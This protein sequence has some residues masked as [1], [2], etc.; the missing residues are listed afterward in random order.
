[1][2]RNVVGRNDGIQVIFDCQFEKLFGRHSRKPHRV[3]NA[4]ASYS[5]VIFVLQFNKNESILIGRFHRFSQWHMRKMNISKI[6]HFKR[7]TF[8]EK[9]DFQ[10]HSRENAARRPEN[11]LLQNDSI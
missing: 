4:A 5:F 6:N 7:H 9:A 1:M 8:I 2:I 11:D 3:F 10:Q